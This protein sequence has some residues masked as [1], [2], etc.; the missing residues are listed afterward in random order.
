MS[1]YGPRLTRPPAGGGI[2]SRPVSA[3]VAL[4]IVGLAFAGPA[5]GVGAQVVPEPAPAVASSPAPLLPPIDVS[6]GGAFL[7][8]VL[9]PGWGHAAIGSH[10]RGGF[11][12]AAQAATVYTLLR[13]RTR[14]GSA[15]DRVRLTQ[16]VITD[17]LAAEGITDPA[18][19]SEAFDADARLGRLRGLLDSRKEQQEDLVALSIFWVL[20]SAADAYVSAHLARFPEPLELD[21]QVGPDGTVGVGLRLSLPN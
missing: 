1:R 16:G 14:I 8:A 12:M 20:I 13:T 2:P 19:V 3:G 6:P 11:Y 7:R 15:Q 9:V 21:T 17:R 18:L 5:L 10:T 4:S